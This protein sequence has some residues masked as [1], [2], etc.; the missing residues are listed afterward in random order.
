M[1]GKNKVRKYKTGQDT[2]GKDYKVKQ[3]ISWKLRRKYRK[4]TQEN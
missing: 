2:L 1:G 3:E 4:Q